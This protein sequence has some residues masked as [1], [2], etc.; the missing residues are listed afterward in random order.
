MRTSYYNNRWT[1]I[2]V[3]L[4][5]TELGLCQA[6][7][8]SLSYTVQYINDSLTKDVTRPDSGSHPAPNRVRCSADGTMQIEWA[9][10]NTVFFSLKDLDLSRCSVNENNWLTIMTRGSSIKSVLTGAWSHAGEAYYFH[11]WSF[12]FISKERAER[13]LTAFKHAASCF[14]NNEQRDPF[15]QPQNQ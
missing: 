7:E 14:G 10:A 9:G 1:A 8:P 12:L 5:W 13:C 3:L 11:D 15:A 6:A 2:L 4:F